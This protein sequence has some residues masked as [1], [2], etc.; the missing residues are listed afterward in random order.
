V[1]DRLIRVILAKAGGASQ[2]RSWSSSS[3]NES[4]GLGERTRKS[5]GVRH[6]V[7]PRPRSLFVA[8]RDSSGKIPNSSLQKSSSVFPGLV[9][10]A[11][12]EVVNFPG[13]VRPAKIKPGIFFGWFIRQK[14]KS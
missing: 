5:L 13:L 10:P 7:S 9:H 8:I 4:S 6:G 12:K 1:F 3:R 2:Q 11:K 14:K